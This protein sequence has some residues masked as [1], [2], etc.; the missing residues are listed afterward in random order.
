MNIGLS[1]CRWYN[2]INGGEKVNIG[3]NVEAGGILRGEKS[4][5]EYE[6]IPFKE[7]GRGV[8]RIKKWREENKRNKRIQIPKYI[9][10]EWEKGC[11]NR[12]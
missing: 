1:V 8:K 3:D 5:I 9:I 10:K 12:N 7:E 2:F 4:G 6:K 11:T